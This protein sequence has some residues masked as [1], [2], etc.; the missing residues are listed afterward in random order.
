MYARKLGRS[1]L[2]NFIKQRQKNSAVVAKMKFKTH[3]K[4]MFSVR[5][6]ILCLL[7]KY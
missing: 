3:S 4:N 1:Y 2:D 7:K 6:A 5:L